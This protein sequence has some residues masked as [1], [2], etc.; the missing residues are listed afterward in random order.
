MTLDGTFESG[1]T[2]WTP[3]N[4]T[5]VSSTSQH[6]AGTHSGLLTV[7]GS[8]TQAYFRGRVDVL[9]PQDYLAS[10]WAYSVAGFANAR[11]SVDWYTAGDVYIQTDSTVIT[12]LPAATWTELRFDVISPDN[13][14]YGMFGGT[15]AS[16]PTTGTAVFFDDFTKVTGVTMSVTEDS[17]WPPR[18]LIEITNLTIGQVATLY[19]V[20]GGQRY[21]V[22]GTDGITLADTTLVVNDG[23]FPFGA[24]FTYLLTTDDGD[25]ATIAPMTATLP[26]GKIALSDAITGLSA[27]VVI[28]SWPEK[29]NPRQGTRFFVGGRNVAVLSPRGGSESTAE[30]YVANDTGRAQMTA[31]LN[32]CTAGIIM[33]RAAESL[34]YTGYDGWYA[35]MGDNETRWKQDGSDQQRLFTLDL[36]ETESWSFSL[37]ASGWTLADIETVYA[38]G[39]LSDLAGDFG[40]LLDIEVYDWGTA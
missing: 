3:T 4:A 20:V 37:L 31:L 33:V 8:P 9:A 16:S 32:G 12:A 19:R 35:V 11:H 13:A 5:F 29:D 38:D 21:I 24:P 14:A 6:H 34:V 28:S 10:I 15:L 17:A 23:E 25:A 18:Q 40:T 36:V 39:A 7:T 30:F 26:G 1:V 22:R 27:E 2:G